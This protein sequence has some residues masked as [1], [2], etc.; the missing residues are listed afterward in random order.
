MTAAAKVVVWRKARLEVTNSE[1]KPRGMYEG[2]HVD[3]R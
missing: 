2:S 3:P 1:N